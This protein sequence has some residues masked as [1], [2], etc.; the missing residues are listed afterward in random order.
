[1]RHPCTRR[2]SV[3]SVRFVRAAAALVT[4]ILLAL[5]SSSRVVEAQQ[6]DIVRGLVTSADSQPLANVTVTVTS[7]SGAAHVVRTDR[8]GWF[9]VAIAGGE[10]D[11]VVSFVALGFTPRRII[12]RRWADDAV[13]VADARLDRTPQP[14]EGMKVTARRAP[15]VDDDPDAVSERSADRGFL[16]P[17]QEGDL[18]ALASTI[19][20]VRLLPSDDG[21]PASFSVL[22]LAPD[23]NMTTLNGLR[24]PGFAVPRDAAL[25]TRLAISPY[26]VSRGGFSGAL[27]ALTT[28]PGSNASIRRASVNL[29]SPRL[30]WRPSGGGSVPGASMLSLS[31]LASGPLV[32][33]RAFYD[34]AWQAGRHS[35]PLQTL[36]NAGAAGLRSN[37]I[38]PDSMSAFLG[39]LQRAG[40]PATVSAVPGSRMNDQGSLLASFDFRRPASTTGETANLLING[41]WLRQDPAGLAATEMPAHAGQRTV[42]SAGIQ[43]THSAYVSGLLS[44]AAVGVSKWR[45]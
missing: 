1:M 36:L 31:G 26:D 21:G 8:R 29:D 6:T 44:E 22:G 38:A 35:T 39:L 45:N 3:A 33:D 5:S 32:R 24:F 20:G 16:T 17:D 43:G 12:V 25:M 37:G 18:A 10:G 41:G 23:Q 14:L 34:V 42:W 15:H 28:R 30:Q 9:T 27:F 11:Y 40:V 7:V 19:P 4:T 2:C 13:I